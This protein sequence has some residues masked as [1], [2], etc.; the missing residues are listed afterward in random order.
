MAS[1]AISFE[2]DQLA[3]AEPSQIRV[4]WNRFR[5]HKL[6]LAGLMTLA[7][8]ALAAIT[9][10]VLTGQNSEALDLANRFAAPTSAHLLGTDELGRDLLTRLLEAGRISLTVSVIITFIT[11][12]VGAVIGATSGFRGGWVDNIIMRAVD[13]I[14]SLPGL[15]LLLV[16]SAILRNI[17]PTVVT[18]VLVL[19]VLGWTG[20]SR[21]VRGQVLTLRGL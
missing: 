10:P 1:P 6:A 18:I 7:L 17:L 21:I 16:M 3:A 15:P 5:K 2:P 14:I 9:G 19:S 12:T 8:L 13:L 11:I 4:T 20:V